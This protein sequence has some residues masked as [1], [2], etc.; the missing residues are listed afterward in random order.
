MTARAAIVG[1]LAGCDAAPPA[2]SEPACR[3]EAWC[4][5]PVLDEPKVP[6][7]VSVWDEAGGVW[8]DGAAAV[9]LRDGPAR[10]LDKPSLS[11]QLRRS[12]ALPVRPG[13]TWAY[14]DDGSDPGVAWREPG[15]DDRSWDYGAGP[16]GYGDPH[17]GTVVD[18]DPSGR[19]LTTF[20]RAGLL[21]TA[22]EVLAGPELGVLRADGVAVYVNG[23]EAHR[24]NLSPAASFETPAEAPADGPDGATWAYTALDPALLVEGW[25]VFAAEVHVASPDS[26]VARFDLSLQ[27]SG[28][29]VNADLLGLGAAAD[30]VLDGRYLDGALFRERFAHDLFRAFGAGPAVESR[31]CE[32]AID[33]EEQ[34]IYSLAEELERG[35]DR[36]GGAAETSGDEFLA[37]RRPAGGLLPSRT[38]AGGWAL[39][40]VA[41]DPAAER[42]VRAHLRAFEDAVL[43]P[44][45][46]GDWLE[47]DAAVDWVVLRELTRDADAGEVGPVL[48]RSGGGRMR[49][50]PAPG[51]ERSLGGAGQPPSG[52]VAGDAVLDALARTPGFVP[53]LAARWSALRRGPLSRSALTAQL[54]AYD[55]TLAPNLAADAALW[56]HGG[57]PASARGPTATHLWAR[58]AWLDANLPLLGTSKE[59]P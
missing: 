53:A 52:F 24:D 1:A 9:E 26:L 4:E 5:G 55:A 10:W 48:W 2:S 39:L 57:T 15:F 3:V 35:P 54:A 32:L 56:P 13:A 27:A 21:L 6:C 12:S 36:V 29:P 28:P 43:A 40:D 42:A 58:L 25:N 41:A 16:L 51:L 17:L 34:G 50:L 7:A 14:L 37:A 18:H 11:L 23:V 59:N 47:L 46:V 38:G 19:S 20:F 49:L 45:G 33:G 44:G 8:Y 30:W 22:P 31:F